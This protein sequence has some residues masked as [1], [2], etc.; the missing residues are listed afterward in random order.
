MPTFAQ[1]IDPRRSLAA[2]VAWAVAAVT[3]LAASLASVWFATVARNEIE[4]QI[5]ARFRQY[6]TQISNEIDLNL[7]AR[8]QSLQSIRAATTFFAEGGA[9]EA[10]ARAG[11]LFPR[12]RS[13]LPELEWIGFAG[14][15]GRVMAASGEGLAQGAVAAQQ[16]WF[17]E[18]RRAAW[19]GDTHDEAAAAALARGDVGEARSGLVELSVP[20]FGA[21]GKLIGV[22]GARLGFEWILALEANLTGSLR[23]QQPVETLL[24]ARDGL[25]LSGPK[26]LLG[27]HLQG[28]AQLA[29]AR[30]LDSVL[31]AFAERKAP[32]PEASSGHLVAAWNDGREYLAGF[33][34]SDGAG[35][36]PGGIGW[37]VWVRESADSAFGPVREQWRQNL[38]TIAL[39]GLF[40]VACGILLALRL[41][42]R[43]ADIAN[44]A[45]DI[46]AGRRQ[47]L[48][49][50]AGRDEAARIGRSLQNLLD[51]LAARTRALEQLNTELD[52]RVA[53][54]T[55]EVERLAEEN[56]QAAMVRE[57]LRFA[58]DLHDTL[59]HSIMELLTQIRLMRKFAGTAPAQLDEELARAEEAARSGLRNARRAISELRR[60]LVREL[61]LGAALRQLLDRIGARSGIVVEFEAD[62]ACESL[63]DERAET[64]YRI[65]EEALGNVERHAGAKNLKVGLRQTREGA[66]AATQVTLSVEDDGVGFEPSASRPGHYGLQGMHEL[67]ELVGATLS[68]ASSPGH[69]TAIVLSMPICKKA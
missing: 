62:S 68:V 53:S 25:V 28:E 12:L 54:R 18:G 48:E 52:A 2:A 15:D 30:A 67:A 44:S 10:A 23:A 56:R 24:V 21:D 5:G 64:L 66:A 41:T 27:R 47:N 9:A 29:S 3:L 31:R 35:G 11:K 46:R 7:Y 6:A 50:P 1:R 58:R 59:A 43:L 63:A 45:D 17:V 20:V 19:I 8:L 13:E 69:G 34:V 33:A 40:T 39:L 65:A 49:V 4:E 60:D 14:P 26:P 42:R 61:G 38:V 22:I 55:R 36:F 51:Q 37:T 16:A 57:R 32:S